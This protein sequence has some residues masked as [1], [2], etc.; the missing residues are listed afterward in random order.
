MGVMLA[1]LGNWQSTG[2][3]PRPTLL[4]VGSAGEEAGG[5][6]GATRFRAWTEQRAI[7]IDQL[8]VAEPTRLAPIHGHKGGVRA[9][10]HGARSRR[11]TAPSRIS[12]RT[13]SKRWHR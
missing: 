13:P 3:R 1:L 6:L 2:V 5:L 10:D 11:A 9:D 7:T 4:L 12:A 8:V